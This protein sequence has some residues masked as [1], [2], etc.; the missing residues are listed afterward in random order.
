MRRFILTF[1][2]ICCLIPIN[3]DAA[4]FFEY[5]LWMQPETSLDKGVIEVKGR[6]VNT[7]DVAINLTAQWAALGGLPSN[8]N[9]TTCGLEC[10]MNQLYGAILNPNEHRDFLWLSGSQEE[11][12]SSRA[13]EFLFGG[14]GLIPYGSDWHW[15]AGGFI[16]ELLV[17]SEWINGTIDETLPYNKIVINLNTAGSYIQ[18][19]PLTSV[20]EPSTFLLLGAGLA[21]ILLFRMKRQSGKV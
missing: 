14:L 10:V 2:L 19:S 21:G 9:A 16:P 15:T 6:V 7:G 20:P 3:S 18:G 4:P 1:L 8:L 13:G 5:E 12:L 17:S 11:D